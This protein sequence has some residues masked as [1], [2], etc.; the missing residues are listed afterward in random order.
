MIP[1]K[2]VILFLVDGMR[3]DG[4]R[5]ADTPFLDEI[6]P[7]GAF[8]YRARSVFPTTTLPCHMSLFHSIPPEV[9]GIRANTWQPLPAPVP[10][11]GYSA[12]ETSEP[13]NFRRSILR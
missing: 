5:R 11:T 4:L 9:H 13:R 6:P 1:V 12:K 8:T 2:H 3:P 7:R 10:S